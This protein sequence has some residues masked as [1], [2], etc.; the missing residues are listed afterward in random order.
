MRVL[1]I[2]TREVARQA[3]C[4]RMLHTLIPAQ[5]LFRCDGIAV[6]ECGG[7]GMKRYWHRLSSGHHRCHQYR[8]HSFLFL[9][10]R[11][12]ERGSQARII[13]HHQHWLGRQHGIA[14][15]ILGHS[16]DAHP[17]KQPMS[18]KLRSAEAQSTGSPASQLKSKN[19]PAARSIFAGSVRAHRANME[20]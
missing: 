1:F 18:F 8:S 6:G 20:F 4:R 3:R 9:H 5:F 10:H 2:L 17:A 14:A 13:R 7:V 11:Y 12:R 15:R 16:L 19:R